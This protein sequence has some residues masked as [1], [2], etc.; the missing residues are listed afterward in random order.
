MA[1]PLL[2]EKPLGNNYFNPK[3]IGGANLSYYF[4]FTEE[5]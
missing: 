5:I 3:V 4:S 2:D 1:Y